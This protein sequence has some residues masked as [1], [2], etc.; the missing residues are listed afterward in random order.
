MFD[1]LKFM[2][3]IKQKRNKMK[4]YLIFGIFLYTSKKGKTTA[5]EIAEN[6][7]ISQRTVYRYID[8]LLIAG[9]PI[10]CEPGKNGGIHLSNNFYIE[11]FCL[12][13]EEKSTLLCAFNKNA[14]DEKIQKILNK[15]CV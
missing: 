11:K 12:S 9:V 5:K 3:Y 2:C 4:Q 7:E 14:I 13:S 15:I 6:F 8:A 10:I 1:F